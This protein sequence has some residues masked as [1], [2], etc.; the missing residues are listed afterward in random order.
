VFVALDLLEASYVGGRK[1]ES[2]KNR[3]TS[4]GKTAE[5]SLGAHSDSLGPCAPLIH[6]HPLM[7]SM[8]CLKDTESSSQAVR[9][10]KA[11]LAPVGAVV[12]EDYL[13][14]IWMLKFETLTGL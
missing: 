2:K 7:N 13:L 4:V 14:V 1:L 10:L 9:D 11:A 8:L 5:Q 6:H 3:F 12:V